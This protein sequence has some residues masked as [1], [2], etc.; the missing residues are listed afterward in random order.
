MQLDGEEETKTT[1]TPMGLGF[2]TDEVEKPADDDNDEDDSEY[3]N[4]VSKKSKF[5]SN[6]F[7]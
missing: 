6:S 7:V 5:N 2:T 4:Q 3:D 1:E